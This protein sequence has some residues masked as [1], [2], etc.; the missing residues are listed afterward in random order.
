MEEHFLYSAPGKVGFIIA[1]SPC[2]GFSLINSRKNSR[3]ALPN[4]YL[5]A[6]VAAYVDFYRPKYALLENVVNVAINGEKYQDQNVFSRTICCLVEMGYQV[7]QFDFNVW[8][9]GSP[10]SRSHLFLSIAA[11]GLPLPPHPGPSHSHQGRL[12]R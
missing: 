7:Q 3:R 1:G 10:Q 6:L 12:K 11:S 2:Q 8:S 9:F 4:C 5:I